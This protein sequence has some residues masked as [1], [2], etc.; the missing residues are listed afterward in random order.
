MAVQKLMRIAIQE[1]KSIVSAAVAKS[2]GAKSEK[3][4]SSGTKSRKK[5]KITVKRRYCRNCKKIVSGSTP[6]ALPNSRY[7]INFMMM[8]V[9]LRLHGMS[10]QRIREIVEII[11]S[12]RITES[13]INR[14]VGRVARD[15][16]PLYGKIREEVRHS[17]AIN[18]D[19]TSWARRRQELLVVDCSK[20]VRRILRDAPSEEL[21]GSKKNTRQKLFGM[22]DI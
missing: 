4:R 3:K 10:H 16:G 6:L 13:A 14:M 7:G 9:I 19:E 18:G 1:A 8:M 2:I 15:L 11:Y 5:S 17:P 20:Q 22:R 12:T 21:K